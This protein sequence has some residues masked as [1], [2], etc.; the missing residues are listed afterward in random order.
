MKQCT[1]CLIY[2]DYENFEIDRNQCKECRYGHRKNLPKKTYGIS[3]LE[4]KCSTC[5]ILKSSSEFGQ[6]KR[7]SDGLNN[8]CKECRKIKSKIDY[9]S[10]KEYHK[11][12]AKKRYEQ[13]KHTEK[14]RTKN[15]ERQKKRMENDP[16]Y[17]LSRRLRN[18]LYYALKQ[19]FWKKGTKFNEYIGCSLDEL[20]TYI[21]N[22]FI[23][24]MS[25]E[26]Q[27]EWHLDHIIPLDSANSEEELYKLCHYTNLQPLWA[28][29]NIVKGKKV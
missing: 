12:R 10:N 1:K 2:K 11:S 16:Y 15:M 19:R 9:E 18:R 26:N 28:K 5:N 21:E 22:L 6:H 17:V 3:V 7:R 27:G 20:K 29:D 14:F 4:K 8:I 23:D 13:V 25:W 24:G